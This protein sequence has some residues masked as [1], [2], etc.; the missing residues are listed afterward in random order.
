MHRRQIRIPGCSLVNE[1]ARALL[2]DRVVFARLEVK[3]RRGKKE[4][5]I[6]LGSTIYILPLIHREARLRKLIIDL[7]V[8][9]YLKSIELVWLGT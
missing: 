1:D 5:A 3:T 4:E 9:N 2:L 8:L 7:A 6:Q